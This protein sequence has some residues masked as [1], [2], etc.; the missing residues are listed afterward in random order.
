M[1]NPDDTDDVLAAE[2]NVLLATPEGQA[3]LRG[4]V[5]DLERDRA[6][7]TA[8]RIADGLLADR[9]RALLLLAAP[10]SSSRH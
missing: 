3:L 6:R 10:L 1:M 8:Q 9:K 7:D 2:L 4:M 5:L